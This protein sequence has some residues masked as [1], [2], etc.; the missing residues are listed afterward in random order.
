MKKRQE[1]K[2]RINR[3]KAYYVKNSDLGLDAKVP[4]HEVL[5]S[6]FSKDRKK[7]YVQTITSLESQPSKSGIRS[8]KSSKKD[9]VKELHDGNIIIIPK[10][11]IKTPKLSGVYKRGIWVDVN[12][13]QPSKFK[14]P[15]PKPYR[16]ILNN[17]K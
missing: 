4:G 5:I 2:M 9:L 14:T 13:L 16:R 10:Q 15:Y 6:R 1:T 3:N 12:K 7:V 11:Y 17:K 8:F